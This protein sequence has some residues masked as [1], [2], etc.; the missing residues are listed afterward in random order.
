MYPNILP[1]D[2]LL[3]LKIMHNSLQKILVLTNP[4]AVGSEPTRGRRGID[5]SRMPNNPCWC[6]DPIV[7]MHFCKGQFEKFDAVPAMYHDQGLIPFKSLAIGEG[8]NYTRSTGSEPAQ[9]CF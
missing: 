7:P 2:I 1:E 4:D 6:L 8:V 5:W 9:N 3:K